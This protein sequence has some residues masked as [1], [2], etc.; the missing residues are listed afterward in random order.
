MSKK[1]GA[2][3]RDDLEVM[4]PV[5]LKDVDEAQGKM[6]NTAKD[7]GAKGEIVI[8]KSGSDDELVY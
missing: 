1:A 8:N 3:L 5:R 7:L 4:G 2:L 6:V